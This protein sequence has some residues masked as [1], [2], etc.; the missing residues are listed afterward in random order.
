MGKNQAYKAML[1][2]LQSSAPGKRKTACINQQR[3]LLEL[4]P[5]ATERFEAAYPIIKELALVGTPGYKAVKQ[6]SQQLLPLAVK[7]MQESSR[8]G[9][10]ARPWLSP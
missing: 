10:T 4:N 2:G 3:F 7:A 1:A 5:R 9:D 6:T 8:H